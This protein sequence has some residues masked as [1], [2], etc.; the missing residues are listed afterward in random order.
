MDD[1]E[2]EVAQGVNHKLCVSSIF[3]FESII[4]FV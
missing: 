3:Y 1:E 2:N 4:N